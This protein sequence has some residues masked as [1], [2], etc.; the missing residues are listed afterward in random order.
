MLILIDL[1]GTIL[2]SVHPT[3]KPYKDGQDNFR[4]DNYLDQLPFF[5]GAKEFIQ[6]QKEKGNTV[7]VVSDSHPRY[8]EPISKYIECDCVSLADKPNSVKLTSYLDSHP[9]YKKM[10]DSGDC[11][12][13]GDTALD[14]EL[15]RRIGVLTIWILQYQITDEIKN[16]KDKVGDE[17]ASLKMGPTYTVKSFAEIQKII[18]SPINNLYTIE[19]IFVGGESIKAIRYSQSKFKDGAYSALRCLA[20]QET[21]EC[22]KYARADKY[23]LISN[24]NRSM[25]LLTNLAAGVSSFINQPVVTNQNWDY[26]TYLAD[27]QTTVPRN[28]MKEI[29]DMIDTTI[30]KVQLLK[31]AD[32][33][34]GSL[35]DRNFY[36]ERKN[37]LEQYLSVNAI[38]SEGQ[39][40]FQTNNDDILDIRGKNII[41]IDDQLT[42]GATA[43]YVI[44]ELKEKGAKNIL[45]IALFQMILP[46][47]SNVFCPSCGKPMRIKIRRN[48]GHK[49]YSCVP[50]KFGGEGCGHIIDIPEQ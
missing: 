46:V 32:S 40:L 26:I 43:W 28:K 41:V 8:V 25:E 49:F 23:Y 35:R 50:P 13:I 6:I 33:V 16:E 31:W 27:K 10:V 38:G 39:E 20:R 44:R 30:P 3:W 5:P 34:S 12:F 2:N 45:F 42:T 18:D 17:M 11:V 15:G 1:D 47:E 9:D 22:D 14:I 7:L 48:D 37:F 29:F 21:G 24:P 19:S 36:E 4:I